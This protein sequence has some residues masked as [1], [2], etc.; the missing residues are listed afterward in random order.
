MNSQTA[1]KEM[2]NHTNGLDMQALVTSCVLL[3]LRNLLPLLGVALS[4]GCASNAPPISQHV[5]ATAESA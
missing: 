2:M 5:Y 3:L 4:L 1:A